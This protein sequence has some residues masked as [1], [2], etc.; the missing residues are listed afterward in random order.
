MAAAPLVR[1]VIL[2]APRTGSNWLCSLLDSHPEVLCHHEIFNPAGIHLALSRRGDMDLGS[3]AERDRDPAAMLARLWRQSFDCLAVGFKITREQPA[4]VFEAVF[5]DPDLRAVVLK[6]RNRVRAFVSERL[7]QETGRWECYQG[8]GGHPPPGRTLLRITVTAAE[9]EAHA[10]KNERYYAG[11]TERLGR[12]GHE[13]CETSYE[14]LP[15][16]AER[17]R[18]L[19]FLGVDQDREL[20]TATR[21]Q[22]SRDLREVIANFDTLTRD[23]RGSPF[24]AE[25]DAPDL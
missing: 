19:A 1:F 18:L 7:A 11:L 5:A 14:D 20:R 17:R 10:A 21:K 4:P 22:G 8:E 16:A 24:A 9:L 12:A 2:A 13:V 6:R 15:D 3:I 25:L 23:L